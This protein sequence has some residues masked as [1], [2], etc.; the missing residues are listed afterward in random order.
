MIKLKSSEILQ[1][2]LA[3]KLGIIFRPITW[4]F[5]GYIPICPF[6]TSKKA[7]TLLHQV[8]LIET[9]KKSRHYLL[10]KLSQNVYVFNH[11]FIFNNHIVFVRLSLYNRGSQRLHYELYQISLG[12]F[13]NT[14][15]LQDYVCGMAES[16]TWWT[17]LTTASVSWQASDRAE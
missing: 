12:I 8:K 11:Q 10:Y 13:S 14:L 17:T 6:L 3:I 1:S 4:T 5:E 7:K 9:D 16:F 15:M 2:A